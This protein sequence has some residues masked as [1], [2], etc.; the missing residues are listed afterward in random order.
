MQARSVE[1]AEVGVAEGAF[2]LKSILLGSLMCVVIG[3]AGPYWKMWLQSSSLFLDYSVGGVMF[4]L[5][6]L[7]LL[8]NGI[9]KAVGLPGALKPGELVVVTA[10]MLVGGAVTTMGLVGYLIP[11]MAAPYYLADNLNN[12]ETQLWPYL[13][14]WAAPLDEDGVGIKAITQFYIGLQEGEQLPWEPWVW[15]L[16]WWGVFVTALYGCMISV[17]TILRKQWV[18]YERLTFPIAQVH[19]ELCAVASDPWRPG[20]LLRNK[21]FWFGFAVPAV[22]C[23]VKAL[24]RFFPG[25]PDLVISYST[26]QFGHPFYIH[27]SYAVLGFTFL[28]PNRVAFSVWF[29]NIL[30][31]IFRCM[32]KK[33]ALEPTVNLG[34]YGVQTSPSMAFQGAGS[35]V[36]F[37]LA[38]LYFARQ[39]LRRVC[40]C[41]IGKEAG[42]DSGE[43]ASYRFA[44][45]V[46]VVSVIV[47]VVWLAAAGMHLH[48]GLAFVVIAILIFLGVTRVVAQCGMSVTITPMI[49]PVL[50]S[51][52]IGSANLTGK[53]IG[54]LAQSWAWNSDIRTSVMSSAAHGMYLAR[55]RGRGLFL[56]LMLAALITFVTAACFT[57]WLGYEHGGANLRK[58]FFSAGPPY[59]YNWGLAELRANEGP[60]FDAYVWGGVGAAITAGLMVANR[61]LFW[62]PIHPVGFLISSVLWTDQLVAT[63][64]LAWALKLIIMKIGGNRTLRSARQFFLG[65]VLGQFTIAGLWNIYATITG[66]VT[67]DVLWV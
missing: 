21:L 7:L 1:P 61:T 54:V 40:R 16:V 9:P 50:M 6:M 20:S 59:Q 11:S 24:G 43:P 41:I 25:L 27:I 33:Y 58:W 19:Q 30:S 15:P 67:L 17:M 64:F 53:E 22:A 29:L 63:V 46:L 55:R 48:L 52:A 4:F 3:V 56:L 26:K 31:F 38:G 47:M 10:M 12:W 13:P 18:D 39:H 60:S 57:I 35:M 42:Y 8:G 62:W 51:Q 34:I 37:T 5:F 23:T 66:T 2:T 32:M 28:I 45:V 49:A 14:S 44:A 36:V 65:M